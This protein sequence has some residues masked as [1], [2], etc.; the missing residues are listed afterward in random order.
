MENETDGLGGVASRLGSKYK[1]VEVVG[2]GVGAIVTAYHR[3]LSRS[4]TLMATIVS[5]IGLLVP[6][7]LQ[8]LLSP[9]ASFSSLLLI[10]RRS[11]GVVCSAVH[12]PTGRSV[13]IKKITF[14]HSMYVRVLAMPEELIEHPQIL[15]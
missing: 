15:V 5:S 4:K 11:D 1:I 13:A 10:T 2:E 14:D 12:R 6:L 8:P 9:W 7:Q 3:Q